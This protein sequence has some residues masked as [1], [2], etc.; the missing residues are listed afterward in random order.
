MHKHSHQKKHCTSSILH[1][2]R[3]VI[4]KKRVTITGKRVFL[5]VGF[6][7]ARCTR[8]ISLQTGW[9]HNFPYTKDNTHLSHKKCDMIGTRWSSNQILYCWLQ[10]LTAR[11]PERTLFFLIKSSFIQA[12]ICAN[13]IKLHINSVF[14][15]I[16]FTTS[17]CA[18]AYRQINICSLLCLF[19]FFSS[20]FWSL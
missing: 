4:D 15:Y 12:N 1:A 14:Q 11:F 5:C 19:N 17:I 9:Y 16:N 7:V 3:Y 6:F 18:T 20:F 10:Q 8:I 2:Q 13:Q